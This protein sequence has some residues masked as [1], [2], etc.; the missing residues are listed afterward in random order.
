[1]SEADRR[2]READDEARRVRRLRERAE[3]RFQTLTKEVDWRVAKAYVALADD[4]EG[5]LMYDL[6]SKETDANG[7]TLGTSSGLEGRAV[8][9]YLDDE[10]WEERELREGRRLGGKQMSGVVGKSRAKA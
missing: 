5:V 7:G 6:K 3:K 2:A 4:P 1:V 10:E 9:W 8:D